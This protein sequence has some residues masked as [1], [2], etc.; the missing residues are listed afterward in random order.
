[1]AL[2]KSL[3]AFTFFNVMKNCSIRWVDLGSSYGT[4]LLVDGRSDKLEQT[5]QHEQKYPFNE[6]PHSYP[7]NTNRNTRSLRLTT[8]TQ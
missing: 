8:R 3:T 2:V 5:T 6:T 7:E 4:S 1:M